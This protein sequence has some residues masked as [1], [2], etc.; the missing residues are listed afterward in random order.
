MNKVEFLP[1]D[2]R[3]SVSPVRTH[4]RRSPPK[5]VRLLLCAWGYSYVTT[6]P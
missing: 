1:P 2:L 5:A 6:V 3:D 4:E